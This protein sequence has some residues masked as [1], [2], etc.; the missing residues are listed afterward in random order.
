[1]TVVPNVGPKEHDTSNP[2][3]SFELFNR[4]RGKTGTHRTA[5]VP[6]LV[7]P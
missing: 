6:Q 4:Y 3:P 5:I 7:L 1:M 2:V